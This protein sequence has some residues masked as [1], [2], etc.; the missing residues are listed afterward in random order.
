MGPKPKGVGIVKNYFQQKAKIRQLSAK[1]NQQNNEIAEQ[2]TTI[3]QKDDEIRR[4]QTVINTHTPIQI[5]EADPFPTLTP[6]RVAE[7]R[8]MPYEEYLQT[9]E[10]KQRTRMMRARFDN[11]CQTC[12]SNGGGR[13]LEVHH[14]HYDDVGYE[15]PTDLTVLCRECHQLIHRM[16]D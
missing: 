15:K 1:V 16:R 4:Q 14:R 2:Q 5:S 8:R 10:W 13:P 11:R 3:N 7:L 9:P 6:G 12:N